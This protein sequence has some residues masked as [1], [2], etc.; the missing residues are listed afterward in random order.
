[1]RI[2][3]IGLISLAVLA[4]GGAILTAKRYL[5]SQSSVQVN[6]IVKPVEEIVT[7]VL[8]ADEKATI[9]STL[10]KGDLR[11]QKWP[12]DSIEETFI[13]ANSKN[14]EMLNKL[15]GTMMKQSVATG[16]PITENMVF[17]RGK[18]GFLS[19]I[20]QE[21][22]RAVTIK[23]DVV[24]GVGGF[25][26]PGDRV[27]ILVTFDARQLSQKLVGKSSAG[28]PDQ[29]PRAQLSGN[30]RNGRTTF[31]SINKLNLNTDEQSNMEPA[32]WSSETIL[33]NVRILAI[34]QAFQDSEKKAEVVKSITL[35][36][37]PKQAEMLAVGRAMG[38]LSLA[39]RSWASHEAVSAEGTY[40]VDADVSAT[41]K[42]MSRKS[43]DTRS[44]PKIKTVPARRSTQ[45]RVI[46]GNKQTTQIFP[47]K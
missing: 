41:L 30:V 47:A 12:S 6:Q 11:W 2:L 3:V 14:H 38:K 23:V 39:L 1:M 25:I 36:V 5:N 35:E 17:R 24:S 42:Y 4:A 27:D 40:T 16:T 19:G 28:N 34:D 21:G 46:R 20:V 13:S 43:P 22:H 15:V 37:T 7:Y 31:S 18:A 45:V 9:G 10:S 33:T 8:V 29:A 26:L 44:N 32:K